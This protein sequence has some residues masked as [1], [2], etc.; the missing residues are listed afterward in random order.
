MSTAQKEGPI[1]TDSGLPAQKVAKR[2]MQR[3]GAEK[4]FDIDEPVHNDVFSCHLVDRA[5]VS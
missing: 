3:V 2:Y 1:T 5:A 4:P